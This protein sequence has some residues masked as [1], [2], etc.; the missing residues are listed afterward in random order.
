MGPCL[1]A[2]LQPE[3]FFSPPFSPIIIEKKSKLQRWSI[4]FS[5]EYVVNLCMLNYGR[6]KHTAYARLFL[7]LPLMS[8]HILLAKA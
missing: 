3:G 1:L 8:I 5:C 2:S 6:L 7:T 4:I